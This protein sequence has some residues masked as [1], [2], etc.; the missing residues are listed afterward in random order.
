MTESYSLTATA[1][2][3]EVTD[4]NGDAISQA[5]PMRE[6]AELL[7]KFENGANWGN[8]RWTPRTVEEILADNGLTEEAPAE[9]APAEVHVCDLEAERKAYLRYVDQGIA[10][11]DGYYA[12]EPFEAWQAFYHYSIGYFEPRTEECTEE[13][14][15]APGHERVKLVQDRIPGKGRRRYR[16]YSLCL[17]CY[18]KREARRKAQAGA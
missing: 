7:G 11:T 3:Y 17:D 14:C 2:G 18:G 8:L 16:T 6:A 10:D 1:A 5:L 12:P 13:E 4:A 9:E 15:K